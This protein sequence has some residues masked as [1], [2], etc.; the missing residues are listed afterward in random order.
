MT[1]TLKAALSTVGAL[2]VVISGVYTGW[3]ALDDRWALKTELADIH[4]TLQMRDNVNYL[5][6]KRSITQYDISRIADI[7]SMYQTRE[8]LNG[9]LDAADRHRVNGLNEDMADAVA[10]MNGIN[11]SIEQIRLAIQ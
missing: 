7:L 1:I 3:Q 4:R 2:I 6:A 5:E 11:I 8:L 9:T 10:I